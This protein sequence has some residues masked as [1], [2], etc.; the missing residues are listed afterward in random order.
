MRESLSMF[1]NGIKDS[2][3]CSES[4]HPKPY[5]L[6]LL[7]LALL[8]TSLH[9]D[10]ILPATDPVY[11]FLES[12]HTLKKSPL[13][14]FQ[15]PLYYN[16]ILST[17]SELRS[18]RH[19]SSYY[20]QQADYHYKRLKMDYDKPLDIAL[21][22]PKKIPHTIGALFRKD[23]THQRLVT[24][25]DPKET[26][27]KFFKWITTTQNETDIYVS[28]ILGVEYDSRV[29]ST[30]TTHRMRKYYGIET[31]GNFTENFGYF[32]MFKKG[33]YTGNEAF[34]LEN[35]Y[36]SKLDDAE[37]GIFSDEDRF[38]RVDMTSELDFK[39]PYLDLSMGYG[40]FDIVPGLT[41]SIVLNSDTTPYGYFKF[42]KS[43]GML[44]YNAITAQLLPDCP[45]P[46][47]IRDDNQ[48]LEDEH[49]LKS[50]ST[51]YIALNS[52][53]FTFGL[54]NSIIYGD[55]TFDIA[56]S[57]PL[58]LYKIMDNKNHGRDNVT[59]WGFLEGRPMPGISL[60]GRFLYDDLRNDRFSSKEWLSYSAY[61][62]GL[63]Y[64]VADL[65]LQIG[66]EATVVGPSTYSHKSGQYTFTT[67]D[68]PLG[69]KHGSNLLNI[70]T[71]ARFTH[72]RFALEL[73]YENLQQGDIG[74]QP[75]NGA[76]DQQF[77]ADKM[78]RK[79]FFHTKVDVS[80]I[81]ELYLFGKYEYQKH[82]EQELHYIYTGA[83]F[84]Y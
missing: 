81:P 10:F 44:E 19:I 39:N 68:M 33:H 75:F 41:S 3:N 13:P 11:P 29:D 82:P 8:F 70:A 7:L 14:H 20:K 26:K 9:A 6:L 31:A 34:I 21:Y 62:A 2:V 48:S 38:Y 24:I 64:Q 72:S 71:R 23:P 46:E 22:P 50:M 49:Y 67:D 79:Q 37:D 35:P 78:A 61:Q 28:G 76:G 1:Q 47:D 55:R 84:K 56:Y 66:G 52:R 43:F 45:P 59:V 32:L 53:S 69:Y 58:A 15:Y 51:Q 60:Y 54:G 65:P 80:I 77:L 12:M 27:G 73:M 5:T 40:G 18:D 42:H 36:I 30:A 83:E 4:L 63:L 16:D 25:T 17:L 57:S 74:S